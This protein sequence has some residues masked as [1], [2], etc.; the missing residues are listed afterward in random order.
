MLKELEYMDKYVGNV[1]VVSRLGQIRNVQ[2]FI[3]QYGLTKNILIIQYSIKDGA[4]L[5]NIIEMCDR[6]LYL[7]VIYLK[8]PRKA[9]K[10][11]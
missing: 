8:L 7:D 11:Y 2:N 3:V 1:F 6:S 9:T 5:K 4:I 10:C